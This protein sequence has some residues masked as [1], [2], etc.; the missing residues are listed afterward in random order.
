[1]KTKRK[2]KELQAMAKAIVADT[3][4]KL[5]KLSDEQEA[6]NAKFKEYGIKLIRGY[7]ESIRKMKIKDIT[8]ERIVIAVDA[9]TYS[10]LEGSTL[11]FNIGYFVNQ[12]SSYDYVNSSEYKE[13]NKLKEKLEEKISSTRFF[14]LTSDDGN[15][16]KT[17]RMDDYS[18]VLRHLIEQD[19]TEEKVAEEKPELNEAI[20]NEGIAL[21][22]KSI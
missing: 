12:V 5:T 6:L 9:I 19:S 3:E 10:M 7:I 8:D 18:S 21:L 20:L 14:M 11:M 15:T 13:L 1:M 16:T 4:A 17:V 2:R 22:T